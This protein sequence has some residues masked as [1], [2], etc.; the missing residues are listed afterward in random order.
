MKTTWLHME[1]VL[2]FITC[3]SHIGQNGSAAAADVRLAAY[4]YVQG[5]NFFCIE[6]SAVRSTIVV[7]LCA[8]EKFSA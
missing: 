4:K 3:P 8:K 6:F 5:L 7:S 2:I 1:F